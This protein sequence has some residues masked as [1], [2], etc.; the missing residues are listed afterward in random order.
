MHILQIA[1]DYLGSGLYKLLFAALEDRGHTHTVFV[2]MKHGTVIPEVKERVHVVPCFS[3]LDRLL[4]YRKQNT[5]LRWM[6]KNLDFQEFDL[7]HAHTVFSGGYAAFQLHKRYGIPYIVAVRDTDVNVFFKF[8]IH[9]RHVGVEILRNASKVIFLSPAYQEKVLRDCVP[10]EHLEEIAAKSVILPNGINK[11]FLENPPAS[12]EAVHDPLELIYV[13]LLNSRKNPE[14][15]VEA[16][17]LLRS[18]GLE[19]KLTVIGA[20]QEEKYRA[21]MQQD[22]ITYHDRCPQD[23]VIAHL[24]KAD[25]FVMPSHRETFGLVYA[26]AMSQGLPVLYT[27]GQGFDGHFPE[28]EVGFS[29]SDRDPADVADKILKI[30][31]NYAEMSKNAIS[32][33]KKFDWDAIAARYDELYRELCT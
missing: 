10:L 29:V 4:F 27:A 26:E 22:F 21:L 6:E 20:I 17:K 3:D 32:G 7:V 30:T 24:R 16:V 25:I 13:G 11:M 15:T 31:E 1:N 19:A 28:G 33:A 14:L 2:P 9:L 8:M 12:K 23:E 5:M 18:R